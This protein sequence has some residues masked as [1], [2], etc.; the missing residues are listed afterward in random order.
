MILFDTTTAS[1]A[2]STAKGI[3]DFGMLAMTAGFYLVLSAVMMVTIFQWFKKIIDSSL[4]QQHDAL[5]QLVTLMSSNL[6]Q[7]QDMAE[8]LRSETLLR[9]RNLTGFAFD[10]SVEQA[11]QLVDKVR[12]ENHIA[13][14][15]TTA[16]KIRKAL[17]VTHDDRSSRFDA[18]TFRGKE[19]SEYCS[20]S[21][22]EDVAL[23]VEGEIYHVDGPNNDRT[24][25]NI[26]LAYDNIKTE[27]YNNMNS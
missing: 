4:T 16:T 23:V 6:E 2:V 26:K 21:W 20:D 5:S 18:F 24:R 7:T 13:D 8:G 22:V 15:E 12:K 1:Q 19:L 3:S 11:C 25:T 27:F 14:H 10:L 9:I 17:Q